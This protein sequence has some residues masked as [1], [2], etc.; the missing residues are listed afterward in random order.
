MALHLFNEF[1]QCLFVNFLKTGQEGSLD[2][3]AYLLDGFVGFF[4]FRTRS[5][6]CRMVYGALHNCHQISL[7]ACVQ[8]LPEFALLF[9]R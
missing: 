6:G 9:S 1:S 5:N 2:S 4:Q 3:G 7:K 8:F